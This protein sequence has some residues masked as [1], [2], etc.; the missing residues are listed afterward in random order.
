MNT[1]IKEAAQ[2]VTMGWVLGYTTIVFIGVYLFWI[3][4]AWSSSNRDRIEMDSRLPLND[5]GES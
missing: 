3:W 4:W 1:V 2:Q 5:G